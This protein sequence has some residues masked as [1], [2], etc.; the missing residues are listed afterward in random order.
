[1]PSKEW[2]V[3]KKTRRSLESDLAA[4]AERESSKSS[5][6]EKILRRQFEFGLELLSK[7]KEEEKVSVMKKRNRI[8]G[9]ELVLAF[10]L[11]T[12]VARSLQSAHGVHF[13]FLLFQGLSFLVMSLD[14]IGERMS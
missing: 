13:Y 3:T 11:L 1:M 14:L 2:V 12:A 10:L 7:L 6:E 9:K 8:Y 5:N 4:F